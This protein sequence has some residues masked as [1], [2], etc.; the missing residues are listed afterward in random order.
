MMFTFCKEPRE[1]GLARVTQTP[2]TQIKSAK[3]ICGYIKPPSKLHN[4]TQWS[5]QIS[6]VDADDRNGWRWIFL[7]KR[8]DL[9]TEARDWLKSRHESL[10]NKYVIHTFD[11]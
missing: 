7:K 4:D 1:T 2:L 8:F 10:C 6:I 11:D 9:E 3:K 5:I